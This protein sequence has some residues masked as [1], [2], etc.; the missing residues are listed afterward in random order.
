MDIKELKQ[1]IDRYKEVFDEA[2]NIASLAAKHGD[3]SSFQIGKDFYFAIS[4]LKELLE[5]VHRSDSLV[6]L[7]L[8]ESASCCE[9]DEESKFTSIEEYYNKYDYIFPDISNEHEVFFT[10]SEN[11]WMLF[12]ILSASYENNIYRYNQNDPLWVLIQRLF[13]IHQNQELSPQE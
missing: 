3:F 11:L 10:K 9:G 6:R 2:S 12:N 1:E 4:P 13:P 5:D 7:D 8:L